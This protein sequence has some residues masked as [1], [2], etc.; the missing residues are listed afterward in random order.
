FTK[1]MPLMMVLGLALLWGTLSITRSPSALLGVL[2]QTR[3]QGPV[4]TFSL[5][6]ILSSDVVVVVLLAAVLSIARPMIEPGAVFSI[7][8]TFR[9]VGH[10]LLGSI[11]LG[12]TLGLILAI[13]CRFIGRQ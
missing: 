5:A 12:T 3:A 4:A 11:A 8:D 1:G 13:Y 7:I 9:E 10:D 6:F 2:A